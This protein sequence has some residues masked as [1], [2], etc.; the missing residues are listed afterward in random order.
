MLYPSKNITLPALAGIAAAALVLGIAELLGAFFTARATP[1]IALGSTFIDFT[2]GWLKDFAIETFGTNDKAALFVGMAV[3]IAVLAAIL[4]VLAYR[5][6]MLGA[7]GVVVLGCVIVAAVLTRAGAEPADMLPTLVGT[8]AGLFA[9]RWMV[10]LLHEGAVRPATSVPAGTG[11][12]AEAGVP[13]EAGLSQRTLRPASAT[14]DVGT[15][16]RR[17]FTAAGITAVVAVAAAA[18]GRALGAARRSVLDFRASLKLPAPAKPAPP[19]PDNLHPDIEGVVP[20][21]TPNPDFYRIDTALRVPQVDAENWEVRVHGMVEKE[22]TMTFAELLDAD[23]VETYVT[24]ACVSNPVGGELVGNA[25]WLGYPLRNLLQRAGPHSDADMVLSTSEDGFTAST[26]IE[27]LQDQRD[28]ILAVAMNDQPLPLEHGYP[29]RIV[30]PGLY[31]FVSATKWV[32]DLEVTRFDRKSAYW[33]ERGWSDRG[34]IKTMS[35]IEVPSTFA[36]VPAGE[37]AI[38]G[39][40]WAQTRGISKVEL[41]LDDGEWQEATLNAEA[42]VDTW[43]QW[44]HRMNVGPG[45][46]TLRSR[47]TDT[48]NGLQTSA[49]A[50]PV[51][52]GASGW[53]SVQFTAE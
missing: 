32:V 34:P 23:L 38:G 8:A 14:I 52:N 49:A 42:S 2:P 53:H 45:P 21:Q 13:A 31:G 10:R 40:A 33:T 22:F 16:R 3:T 15:S 11:I 43:R 26:P 17:F 44:H 9:L 18:G 39:T 30:V 1:L 6:W 29:V 47:A 12:P 7:L 41:Q 46:H 4:G 25:K 36:K 20:W 5:R 51:P 48:E 50:N 27:V 37:L 24:L 28:A 19:L 35:R